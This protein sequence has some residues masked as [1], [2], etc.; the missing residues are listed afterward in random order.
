MDMTLR[1]SRSLLQ[2]LVAEAGANKKEICGLL[3]RAPDGGIVVLPC[4]NVHPMPA[5]RFEL[6]PAALLSAHR[7]ARKGGDTVVGHYHSHPSGDAM[8]SLTDAAQATAD[9][10]FPRVT[11]GIAVM[12]IFVI[13]FNRLLWRPLYA[14]ADRRLRLG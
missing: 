11:L 7:A 4:A 13:G 12:S 2:W 3:L 1:I 6:D 14:Y 5:T 8:P 10:D 9:G